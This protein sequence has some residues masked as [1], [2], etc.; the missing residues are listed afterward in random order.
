MPSISSSSST[1]IS[2]PPTSNRETENQVT[3]PTPTR[4]EKPG[5]IT[6][7]S[8][9]AESLAS[10]G[11]F[12][13]NTTATAS[14]QPSAGS[15]AS[16]TDTSS[17]TILPSAPDAEARQAQ[18]DWSESAQLNAGKGLESSAKPYN[19]STGSGSNVGAAPTGAYS[20]GGGA[21]GES[22]PAGKNISEGG[23][24]GDA[25]NASFNNDVGGKND[26]A[27][28]ALGEFQKRA[29][30]SGADAGGGGPRQV[31]VSDDGQ[32]EALGGDTSA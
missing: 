15:T 11:S 6:S 12:G 29:A 24:D 7:D 22:K 13:A 8:L 16:N 28:V 9:A 27:R 3:D 4:A 21:D 25:P 20:G 19:A 26:P 5:E 31:G 17:A 10:N 23:F 2:T 30:T 14:S 1:S 18:E 32:F